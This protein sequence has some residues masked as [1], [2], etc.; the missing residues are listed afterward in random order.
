AV[1]H[2]ASTAADVVRSTGAG[3]VLAFDGQAE[4]D[5]VEGRFASIFTQ[6][7]TFAHNF[8]PSQVDLAA[9]NAY[10]ARSSARELANALDRALSNKPSSSGAFPSG[11]VDSSVTLRNAA[12]VKGGVPVT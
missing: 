10:S 1:L 7:R 4:L 3:H 5:L 12:E 8:D 2:S 11:R 6:F 9:F